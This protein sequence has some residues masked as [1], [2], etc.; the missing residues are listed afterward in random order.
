MGIIYT[1]AI[2]VCHARVEERERASEGDSGRAA[3]TTRGSRCPEKKENFT[4]WYLS[5][6]RRAH[7]RRVRRRCG[8][9]RAKDHANRG[10]GGMESD[11]LNDKINNGTH[12]KVL[13]RSMYSSI[14][15]QH[16]HGP[17]LRGTLHYVCDVGR[18]VACT[19]EAMCVSLTVRIGARQAGE[20]GHLEETVGYVET[21]VEDEL[22]E[23]R[24]AR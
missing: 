14:P 6:R 15:S 9:V 13:I 1:S 10:N 17:D 16:R 21:R 8:K 24:H 18:Q 22:L 19:C 20:L 11:G 5:A 23:A 4:G 3:T 7:G 2:Q 12:E